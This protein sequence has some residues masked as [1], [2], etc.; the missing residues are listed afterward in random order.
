VRARRSLQRRAPSTGPR[1][2]VSERLPITGAREAPAQLEEALLEAEDAFAEAEMSEADAEDSRETFNALAS[3]SRLIGSA[4]SALRAYRGQLT[5]AAARASESA[6]LL[7]HG[8]AGEGKTHLLCDAAERLLNEGHPAVVLLGGH[9]LPSSP[10]WST[11]AL[12]LGVGDRGY[13]LLVGAMEAAA[14]IT[15]RRFVLLIDASN[16]TDEPGFWKQQLETIRVHAA[17]R[18]LIGI[19]TSCRTTYLEVVGIKRDQTPWTLIEHRGLQGREN[20]AAAFG[21]YGVQAPRFRCSTPTSQHPSSSSSTARGFRAS[22]RQRRAK[23]RRRPSSSGSLR[24][25]RRRLTAGST[26]TRTTAF[27]SAQ[28]MPSRGR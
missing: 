20:E 19:G 24:L 11:V 16:E 28:W 14:E 27:R 22:P 4:Y 6:T 9:F 26:S 10:A 21:H 12:E 25:T 8:G 3:T 13:E 2:L 15:G 7:I 18:G 1:S 17:R 5:A 23:T